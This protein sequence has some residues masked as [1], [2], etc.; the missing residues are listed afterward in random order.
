MQQKKK[1]KSLADFITMPKLNGNNR[2]HAVC[3]L[4]AAVFERGW[5]VSK[6][7]CNGLHGNKH[8]VIDAPA[9]AP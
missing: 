6:T 7:T 9:A 1:K 3:M 4:R 8:H 5:L 2:Q